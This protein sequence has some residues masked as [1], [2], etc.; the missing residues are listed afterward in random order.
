MNIALLMMGGSGTRFGADR[1]KQYVL[2]N[3]IP[4]FFYIFKKLIS[5]DCIDKVILV[6][7]K[8]WIDFVKE[9]AVKVKT[10]KEFEIVEGGENRSESV[11]HGLQVAAKFAKA[12]DVILIHD[13]THPYVDEAGTEK[14]IAG[15]KKYG[16]ATLAAF[17]YDTCYTIDKEHLIQGVF[18][19]EKIVA[20]ASPEAFRFGEIYTIYSLA[21]KE[22]LQQMTSAGAIALAHG[23]KMVVVPASVVNLKI[24]YPGDMEI[25]KRIIHTYDF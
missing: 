11:L 6:S 18:P 21:T 20:G 15:V 5:L 4:I 9:W 10:N 12:E 17:Q 19:R 22:E 24:T 2:V 3:D 14:V 25:F 16:G 23:I 13:V 7:H 8:S 1:P